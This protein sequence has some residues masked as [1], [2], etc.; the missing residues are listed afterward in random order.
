[1]KHHVQ[2]YEMPYAD[3]DVFFLKQ[4]IAYRSHLR[5]EVEYPMEGTRQPVC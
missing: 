3:V 1:M 4:K 5:T 2:G